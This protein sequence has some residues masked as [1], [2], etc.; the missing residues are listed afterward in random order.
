MRRIIAPFALSILIGCT[1][2]S[3]DATPDT[4]ET[5]AVILAIGGMLL[6]TIIATEIT[7]DSVCD[8]FQTS[9]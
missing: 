1:P 7:E 9:C 2:I 6:L 5:E 3:E 8:T 4:S